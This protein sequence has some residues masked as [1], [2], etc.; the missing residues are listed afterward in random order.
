MT[1]INSTWFL[2]NETDCCLRVTGV[3]E[4]RVEFKYLNSASDG[5][6]WQVT[7]KGSADL[8]YWNANV[9]N[10]TLTEKSIRIES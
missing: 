2:E 9:Q 6:I 7:G 10:G 8:D 5:E 3:Q 4:N 1:A